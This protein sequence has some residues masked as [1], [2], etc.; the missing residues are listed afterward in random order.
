MKNTLLSILV[1]SFFYCPA[2][3]SKLGLPNGYTSYILTS[4]TVHNNKLLITASNDGTVVVWDIKTQRLLHLLYHFY[5]KG[6]DASYDLRFDL[7]SSN[8]K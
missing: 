4:R 6:R 8:K 5:H 1:L 2:Q 7:R 3:N